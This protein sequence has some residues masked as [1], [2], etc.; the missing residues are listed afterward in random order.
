M[1]LLP[2]TPRGGPVESPCELSFCER[3]TDQQRILA[4]RLRGHTVS[5]WVVVPRPPAR[6]TVGSS[7]T[8]PSSRAGIQHWKGA[9]FAHSPRNPSSRTVGFC[10]SSF[11]WPAQIRLGLRRPV[12][13]LRRAAHIAGL[14]ARRSDGRL[15]S[16]A[17]GVAGPAI[18]LYAFAS[19]YASIHRAEQIR[20][21]CNMSWL[22]I[23]Q[24]PAGAKSRQTGLCDESM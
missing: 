12:P 3:R 2:E 15:H 7:K 4:R 23:A 20:S 5:R 19:E 13:P 16:S 10:V 24:F 14:A 1:A 18:F 8:Q 9:L 17:A 21:H 6:P 22:S 11:S